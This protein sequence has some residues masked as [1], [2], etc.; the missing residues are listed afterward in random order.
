MRVIYLLKGAPGSGNSSLINKLG[1]QDHVVSADSIRQLFHPMVQ[2][3]DQDG[4]PA[5][6]MSVKS[7][8]ERVIFDF[9]LS[10]VRKRMD[11][12]APIVVDNTNIGK[13]AQR[14]FHKIAEDFGYEVALVDVQGDLT[15]DE[16]QARNA[17]RKGWKRFPENAVSNFWRRALTEKNFGQ[18]RVLSV[19]EF[20]A[21]V[22]QVSGPVDLSKSPKNNRSIDRVIIVGDVQSCSKPLEALIADEDSDS[23]QF[24]FSGDLFD[25]GPDPVGVIR[26]VHSLRNDPILVRGNHDEHLLRVLADRE[27]RRLPQTRETVEALRSKGIGDNLIKVFAESFVSHLDFEFNDCRFLV[28]HGGLNLDV[29]DDRAFSND[30]DSHES[31]R[32]GERDGEQSGGQSAFG[33][34]EFF[35]P[36]VSF[37]QG[38]RDKESVHKGIGDYRENIDSLLV[39]GPYDAQFH[40][41]RNHGRVEANSVPGV[42]NLESGVEAGGHLSAVVLDSN[43]RPGNVD[44]NVRILKY[45]GDSGARV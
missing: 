15:L 36:E 20:K 44:Q 3:Q 37:I 32:D 8:D 23:T 38:F 26:A 28:S 14:V 2:F 30:S 34:R 6:Q 45:D 31:D 9:L 25:R 12:G 16:I 21:E 41:H 29:F 11:I 7:R 5:F 43:V 1:I 42:F 33:F 10:S 40:G 17:Q 27:G 19:D 4:E 39:N 18:P 35:V 22:N 24:I 13:S